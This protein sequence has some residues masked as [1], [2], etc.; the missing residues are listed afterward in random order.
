MASRESDIDRRLT[1]WFE[2]DFEHN[3]LRSINLEMGK[4]RALNPFKIQFN[5]PITLIA[6]ANGSGKSTLLAIAACGFHNDKPSKPINQKKKDGYY[7]FSNFFVQSKQEVPPSGI[8]ISYAI[9]EQSNNGDDC[10]IKHQLKKVVNGKWTNYQ[11]RAKRNVE[12][13]GI[14]RVVPHYEKNV[15]KSYRRNFKADGRT[16]TNTKTEESVGRILGKKYN[17]FELQKHT[18]H[19]LPLV[20][21]DT[22]TYSGF[23]MGAGESALFEIFY[24][25]HS[26]PKASLIVIDEIELGLHSSAQ[27]KFIE[28]LKILCL[29]KK[30]QIIA[31]THSP[32][33]LGSVPPYGRFYI[34]SNGEETDVKECV[35]AEYATGLLAESN[36]EELTILIEDELAKEIVSYALSTEQRKR[37]VL[38][39]VGSDMLVIRYLAV[40]HIT[41][42]TNKC[43]AY[44]DGDKCNSQKVHV[45]ELIRYFEKQ[46]KQYCENFYKSNV[47]FLGENYN[48][49]KWLLIMIKDSAIAEF[50]VE[51][52]IT[53]A[54]AKSIVEDALQQKTHYELKK[55]SELLYI[56][57]RDVIRR[58]ARV[59]FKKNEHLKNMIAQ[60]I[61]NEIDKANSLT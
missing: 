2:N 30:L 50:A 14:E 17:N 46:D 29:K 58:T 18:T 53:E 44:L 8:S 16:D 6:G 7:T 56:D 41:K 1:G 31:T 40:Q 32:T 20:S 26:C 28:E 11:A 54:K 37:V 9:A 34:E 22:F 35:T 27:I 59:L 57:L 48:P 12:Y 36:S 55:T 61:Q 4:L 5:Y 51:F 38:T 24:T 15:S 10:L 13:F 45:E 49:E 43:I 3:L 52:D 25:L 42:N 33:A 21:R 39:S 23:N 19:S 60:T 47:F